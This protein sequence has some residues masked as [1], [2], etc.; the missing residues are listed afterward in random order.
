M[1]NGVLADDAL[2]WTR[3]TYRAIQAQ[4]PNHLVVYGETGWA[5]MKHDEGEQARLIKGRPGEEEQAAFYDAVTSWAKNERVT[6]FFFEAFDEN[7][8]GGEHADEVE[9]HWGL[10]RA[11]RTPKLAVQRSKPIGQ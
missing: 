11:D 10:Y 2:E 7:W 6:V 3:D 8:K 4:H 5:T 9:K 1:W